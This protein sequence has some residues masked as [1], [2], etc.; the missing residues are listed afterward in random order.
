MGSHDLAS[1]NLLEEIGNC[2]ALMHKIPLNT[3][4]QISEN[5]KLE[6]FSLGAEFVLQFVKDH[7][8]NPCSIIHEHPFL[9]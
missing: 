2:I 4:G 5:L 1:P 6:K 9:E 7:K 3:E 8:A